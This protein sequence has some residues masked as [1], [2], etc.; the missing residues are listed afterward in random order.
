MCLINLDL[1][2][3]VPQ[4]VDVFCLQ[5]HLRGDILDICGSDRSFDALRT[6][7]HL[8]L[9]YSLFAGSPWICYKRCSLRM[10]LQIDDMLKDSTLLRIRM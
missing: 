5:T 3:Y 9:S 10:A 7:V 2:I 8:Q 1:L 4:M 6:D